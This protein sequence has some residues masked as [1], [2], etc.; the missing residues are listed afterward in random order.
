M[1]VIVNV[2]VQPSTG[3]ILMTVYM[4]AQAAQR[5]APKELSIY[6]TGRNATR[7][8]ALCQCSDRADNKKKC[9]ES[10]MYRHKG[11]SIFGFVPDF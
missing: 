5:I 9:F 4:S 8:E 6:C 11:H 1:E 2:P 7:K 3:K 10:L